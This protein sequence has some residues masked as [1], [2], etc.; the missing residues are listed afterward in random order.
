MMPATFPVTAHTDY[1]GPGSTFVAIQ[2]LK[3]DGVSFIP[4]AIRKG[5]SRI[6]LHED[7]SL[8]EELQALIDAAHVTVER[9]SDTRRALAQLSA[10]AAGYPAQMLTIIGITGTKGKTTTTFLIEHLLR[11][12]GIKVA[13]LSTVSNAIDGYVLRAPLTTAQPDYL[14]MFFKKCIEQD[15]RHVVMEVSAQAVTL[16]RVDGI[17]FDKVIFTN[18]SQEHGE[19]YTSMQE[20]FLAKVSLFHQCPQDGNIFVNAD[21]AAGRKIL[22]KNP[23]FRSFSIQDLADVAGSRKG[24][25]F[26]IKHENVV[27]T[28]VCPSLVGSYN[29]SNLLA[30]VRVTFALGVDPKDIQN[31]LKQPFIVPGRMDRFALAN[32]ADCVIDYAHNPASYEAVL[33]VLR[34]LYS[35]VIVV[36]GAGGERDAAKRPMMGE[37][38]A[39]YADVVILTSDNPRSEDPQD[40]IN[41]IMKGIVPRKNKHILSEL[42]REKAI[43]LAYR[44]SKQGGVIALLGKGPDEYQEVQGKKIP[45]HEKQIISHLC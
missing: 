26:V 12:A 5:A 40:I 15:V 27:H 16:G 24:I 34:E 32:G 39:R 35:H 11:H 31:A 25:S 42:N 23:H 3:L 19:F 2:G 8:S 38:A 17:S 1:V 9:V 41:D 14:H 7:V 37:I 13:R 22:K 44:L 10:Q 33:S 36:F 18:F 30:A 43:H 21:D 45:F 6:V 28:M 20:Y 4:K 29:V